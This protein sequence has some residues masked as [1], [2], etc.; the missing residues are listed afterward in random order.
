MNRNSS[1]VLERR[2]SIFLHPFLVAAAFLLALSSCV[3]P[4]KGITP[5]PDQ[6]KL[7]TLV[8]ATLNVV[9]PTGT[10]SPSPTKATQTATVTSVPPPNDYP[11]RPPY[12]HARSKCHRQG[13]LSG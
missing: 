9:E 7:E 3:L 13:M 2:W 4:D 11:Y 10:A 12:T 5:T 6:G 1:R 8:A